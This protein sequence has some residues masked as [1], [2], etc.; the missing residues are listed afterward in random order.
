M[1]D[2]LAD[3]QAVE[4]RI[5]AVQ[6]IRR[7][8]HAIGVV[9]QAQYSK[10]ATLSHETVIYYQRLD[11]MIER[12]AGSSV[13]QAGSQL[14]LILG[15]ERALCGSLVAAL[16]KVIPRDQPLALVGSR[17]IQNEALRARAVFTT[18][19]VSGAGEIEDKAAELGALIL[20]NVSNPIGSAARA[21][22]LGVELLFPCDASGATQHQPLIAGR[23]LDP[24]SGF[25]TYSKAEAVLTA[26]LEQALAGRLAYGLAQTLQAEL[27]ARIMTSQRARSACDERL[28]ELDGQW[29]FVQKEQITLELGEIVAARWNNPK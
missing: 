17:L 24:E 19:G 21:E 16:V 28:I 20:A 12:L 23:R 9:S 27:A 15:P 3:L 11:H 10:A 14:W 13:R 29:R 18:K 25:E 1:D 26:A 4:R 7:V 2:A 5:T 6:T 8:M 22:P